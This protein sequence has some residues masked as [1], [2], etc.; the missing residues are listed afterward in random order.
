VPPRFTQGFAR[1]ANIVLASFA[2]EGE[3]GLVPQPDEVDYSTTFATMLTH[4]TKLSRL[5]LTL[6]L[7]IAWL[8]PLWLLFEPCT[9]GELEPTRRAEVLGR[10]LT[11]RWFAVR[12]LTLLLKIGATLAMFAS[13][14]LR[15]R[16]GYDATVPVQ[17][18]A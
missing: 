10:L 1:R 11:H 5:G 13:P 8:S 4:G 16:S 7:W 15:A 3:V 14:T 9:L 2:P 12:E 6:A 18:R 17:V